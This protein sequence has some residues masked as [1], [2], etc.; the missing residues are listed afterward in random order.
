MTSSLRGRTGWRSGGL[1][2]AVVLVVV[3]GLALSGAWDRKRPPSIVETW[4][5]GSVHGPWRSVFHGYGGNAG[6][7]DELTL[8]PRTARREDLTHAC[9]VVS[10]ARYGSVD[11]RARMRT[12]EQLRTPEPNPWEVAWLV[13]AYT[14]PEHF[15]Y[16]A[17]KPNG[18]ELGKRDPAYRG[19]QRFLAT[20]TRPFPVGDWSDVRV[21]QRGPR[22]TVSVDD[23][24]VV[25]FTDRE[26]PYTAGSVGAYTEDARAEFRDITVP[27]EPSDPS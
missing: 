3:G 2:L 11:F 22:M 17:L 8:T 6:G 13:W 9:L 21:R 5:D 27:A 4:R 7:A 25:G 14:D 20:G 18:W 23:R 15:Y 19:G 10:T 1:V 12:A 24:H 16:V 26:R